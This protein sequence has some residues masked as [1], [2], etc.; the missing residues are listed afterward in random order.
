M[1]G[2]AKRKATS[3][4]TRANKLAIDA[5]YSGAPGEKD[6]GG[7]VGAK[8]VKTR[9]PWTSVHGWKGPLLVLSSLVWMCMYIYMWLCVSVYVLTYV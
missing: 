5:R 3:M 7:G 8:G 2:A 6:V 1:W 4:E 9:R